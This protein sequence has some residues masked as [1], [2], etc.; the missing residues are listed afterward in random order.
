MKKGS[1][2]SR[3]EAFGDSDEE[4]QPQVKRAASKEAEKRIKLNLKDEQEETKEGPKGSKVKVDK[5]ISDYKWIVHPSTRN[6]P[7]K[8]LDK[9]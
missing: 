3:K 4:Q 7:V 5:I 2:R 9:N 1:K 8:T 6:Q